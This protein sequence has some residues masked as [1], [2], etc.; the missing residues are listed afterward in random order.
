MNINRAL[1]NIKL[2]VMA[3]FIC[4][5]NK[6]V[7]ITTNKVASLLDLQTIKKYMHCIEADQIESLRL[8]QSKLFLKIISISYISETTNTWIS[9]DKIDKIMKNNHIFNNIVL[10]SKPRVIK[11]L[12]KSDMSIVW[13]D[14]W[15]AQS[16]VK[17]KSLI[18]RS[19][20]IRS[21]IAIIH[22]ANMNPGIPQCKNC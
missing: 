6:R 19:F 11:V 12:P 22:S 1:K 3:D 8:P 14:I 17:A 5:K 7:I 15:D 9:S 21:F 2:E 13:I 16:S 18:N 10:A 20:N 4:I